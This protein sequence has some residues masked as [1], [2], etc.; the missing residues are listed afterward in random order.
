MNHPHSPTEALPPPLPAAGSADKLQQDCQNALR[1]AVLFLLRIVV[2]TAMF[3]ATLMFLGFLLSIIPK[4][5]DWRHGWATLVAFPLSFLGSSFV[6]FQLRLDRSLLPL[7]I[8]IL[9]LPLGVTLLWFLCRFGAM[10][11]PVRLLSF[12]SDYWMPIDFPDTGPLAWFR[13]VIEFATSLGLISLLHR[14]WALSVAASLPIPK[15]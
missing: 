12:T 3:I 15:K 11:L 2:A 13:L 1:L 6:S 8:S 5:S 9:A 7:L 4:Q 10:D 14:A